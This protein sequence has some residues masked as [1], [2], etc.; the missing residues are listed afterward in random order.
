MRWESDFVVVSQ[1]RAQRCVGFKDRVG[2]SASSAPASSA[3]YRSIERNIPG[4]VSKMDLFSP[5]FC[6]TFVPGTSSVPRADFVMFAT[7]NCSVARKPKC[8]TRWVVT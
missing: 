4:A 5:A 7:A 1:H 8:W 6:R 3:L 2:T